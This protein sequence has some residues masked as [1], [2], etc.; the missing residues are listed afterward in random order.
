MDRRG[1]LGGLVHGVLAL[2]GLSVVKEEEGLLNDLDGLP[3]SLYLFPPELDKFQVQ[4]GGCDTKP[5]SGEFTVLRVWTEA[6]GPPPGLDVYALRKALMR[7]RNAV[8]NGKL[9][10]V[11]PSKL[12]MSPF[13]GQ[14]N[15]E[16]WL[17]KH[18]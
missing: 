11:F 8:V 17:R 5:E 15:W 10:H 4:T 6:H 3:S 7:P 14:V 18:A 16:A 9:Y 2:F 13:A 1:F 12:E